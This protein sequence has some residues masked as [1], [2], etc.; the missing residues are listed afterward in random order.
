MCL[1]YR[2]LTLSVGALG[3]W[4]TRGRTALVRLTRLSRYSKPV[5]RRTLLGTFN[6]ERVP[7]I[8]YDITSFVLN[9]AYAEALELQSNFT[10]VHATFE[11]FLEILRKDLEALEIRLNA[12]TSSTSSL[13]SQPSVGDVSQPQN[14]ALATNAS[15]TTQSSTEDKPPKNKELT[16]KRT[17]YGI[18]WIMYIRFARRA[19]SLKS[20]RNVFGKARRDRWTPWEVHEAEGP[21][22][23]CARAQ[24]LMS[25]CSA[26][27]VPLRQQG[28][29]RCQ[30]DF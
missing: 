6:G 21:S 14:G 27:G 13:S 30:S 8:A 23:S 12:S 1:S 22:A 29:S 9:F 18:A 16:D 7:F 20:A 28:C 5:S 3:S 11:K 15:F 17:D 25:A 19:E 2:A 24:L 10:E 26:H 4:H